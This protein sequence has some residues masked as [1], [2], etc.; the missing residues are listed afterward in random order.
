MINFIKNLIFNKYFFVLIIV[1]IGIISTKF[2][3]DDNQIEEIAEQIIQD[4]TG[5]DLDLSPNNK[6]KNDDNVFKRN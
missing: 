2:L 4:E 6:E 1:F 3:G 5:L